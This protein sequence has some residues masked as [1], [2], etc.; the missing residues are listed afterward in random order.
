MEIPF[1]HFFPP[2]SY[3]SNETVL[4]RFGGIKV[5]SHERAD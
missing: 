4:C 1:R 2:Q 5:L 3:Y